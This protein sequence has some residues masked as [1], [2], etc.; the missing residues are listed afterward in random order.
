[1]CLR[2]SWGFFWLLK[3]SPVYNLDCKSCDGPER[4]LS[5]NFLGKLLLLIN[6]TLQLFSPICTASLCIWDLQV[7]LLSSWNVKMCMLSYVSHSRGKR[8]MALLSSSLSFIFGLP[9]MLQIWLV[10]VQ[11]LFQTL[12]DHVKISCFLSLFDKLF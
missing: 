3:F 7:V 4:N 2:L 1:M 12:K 6:K 5:L 10:I 8:K 11:I 9:A